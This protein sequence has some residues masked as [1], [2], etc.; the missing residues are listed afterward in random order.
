MNEETIIYKYII[1]NIKTIAYKLKSRK[2]RMQTQ[3]FIVVR[4][5]PAYVHFHLASIP[6]LRFHLVK[7]S[8][9]SLQAIQLDYSSNSP[10][11][12]FGFKHPLHFS[13]DIPLLNNPSSDTPHLR[14]FLTKIYK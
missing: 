13:R 9:P 6:S 1:N 8:K 4:R 7:A 2:E 10:S 5:N 12:T 11:W 14:K 3:E